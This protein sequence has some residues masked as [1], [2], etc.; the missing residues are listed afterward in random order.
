LR[1][2]ALCASAGSA[3]LPDDVSALYPDFI[4]KL[5]PRDFRLRLLAGRSIRLVIV[6]IGYILPRRVS[7]GALLD[8]AGAHLK[9]FPAKNIQQRC[10]LP[11]SFAL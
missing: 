4:R 3:L 10:M 6:R 9:I 11:Q 2:D 7:D 1:R 5:W 8:V